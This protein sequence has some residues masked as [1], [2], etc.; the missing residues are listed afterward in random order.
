MSFDETMLPAHLTDIVSH[1]TDWAYRA[2]EAECLADA[3]SSPVFHYT[4][5]QGLE[6]ILSSGAIRLTHLGDLAKLGDDHEFLYACN[7]ARDALQSSYDDAVAGLLPKETLPLFAQKCFTDGS[8][9]MLEEINPTSGPFEFYSASFCLQGDDDFLWREYAAKG[10]GY[11]LTLS[12]ILFSE[13]PGGTAHEVMEK[14]F[15]V[16]MRYDRDRAI[17]LMK[18]GVQEAVESIGGAELPADGIMATTFF[19]AMS[20]RL[21]DYVIRISSGF[22][23]PCY[24]PEKEM[25]LLLLNERKI[26]APLST[27]R[28]SK[29]R[30]FI[31]YDFVPPLRSSGVL[32]EIAIGPRAP[33]DAEK[34]VAEL[35]QDH[36]YPIGPDG[37]PLILIRRSG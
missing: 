3:V 24:S 35:L 23:R 12:P 14:I 7:L 34:Q 22:K 4:T 21:L 29:G 33:A 20:V 17:A 11:V 10:V 26:L 27:T 31:R 30:R 2:V 36:G 25:R 18:N 6:G 1:F 19:H 32:Q 9:S 15:R 37:K 8:L 13:P 5:Q 28:D 16:G